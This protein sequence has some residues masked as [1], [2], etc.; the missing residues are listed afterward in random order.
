MPIV[1]MCDILFQN[2]V[3]FF[4]FL[5]VGPS[6]PPVNPSGY[7]LSSTSITLSWSPPPLEY[8]NGIIRSYIINL[9]ELETSAMYS[10]MFFATGPTLT[11][12]IPA[13]HPYY[14]Y[15][16]TIS[17]V[18]IESGPPTDAFTVQTLEDGM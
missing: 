14:T 2:S 15:N 8:Q 9:T 13:L 4:Y 18:T 1:V 3:C 7:S 12:T 6:A 10:Y 17:A 11:M 5:P 16:F